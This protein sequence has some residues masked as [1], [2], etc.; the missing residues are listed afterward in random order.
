MGSGWETLIKRQKKLWAGITSGLLLSPNQAPLKKT[1]HTESEIELPILNYQP[2]TETSLNVALGEKDNDKIQAQFMAARRS[3][4]TNLILIAIF[5]TLMSL[6][7]IIP[8]SVRQVCTEI[9]FSFTKVAMPILTTISNFGT[10]QFVVRQ[11]WNSIF[12]N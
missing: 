3:M 11:Y 12:S 1:S 10:V 6:V 2:D 7:P 8:V 9:M 5:I 4:V